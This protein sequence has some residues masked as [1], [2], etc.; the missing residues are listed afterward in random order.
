MTKDFSVR[1]DTAVCGQPHAGAVAQGYTLEEAFIRAQVFLYNQVHGLDGDAAL[2]LTT[3]AE[4]SARW[5]A[6]RKRHG[7]QE[8]KTEG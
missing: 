5:E 8:P 4:Q 3:Q 7:I 1:I 2:I 6:W